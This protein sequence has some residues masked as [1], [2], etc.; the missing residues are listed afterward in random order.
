MYEAIGAR[1][2]GGQARRGLGAQGRAR[3]WATLR[4]PPRRAVR[5]GERG[6][7]ALR[8][9]Q[10]EWD[11]ALWDGEGSGGVGASRASLHWAY[12]SANG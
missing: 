1:C 11:G 7:E 6:G 2:P 9:L 4:D 12:G 5:Q 3:G 8:E 10:V